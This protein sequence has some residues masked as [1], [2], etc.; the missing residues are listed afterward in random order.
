MT[1]ISQELERTAHDITT[2]PSFRDSA[3]IA[4][5]G[6]V[7]GALLGYV[8]HRNRHSAVSYAWWGAGVGIVGQYMVFHMLKPAMKQFGRSATIAAHLGG[9]RTITGSPLAH[10]FY[11]RTHFGP[12]QQFAQPAAICPPGMMMSPLTGQCVPLSM[13]GGLGLGGLGG[14]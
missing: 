9:G 7:L 11:G 4:I 6:G 10:S 12:M 8:K 1:T 14:M 13:S 5:A 2:A 3:E